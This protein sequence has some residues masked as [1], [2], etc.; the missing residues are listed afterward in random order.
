M[1]L[2]Q[3]PDLEKTTQEVRSC[4]HAIQGKVKLLVDAWVQ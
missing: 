2:G 1:L 4:Q 3:Y